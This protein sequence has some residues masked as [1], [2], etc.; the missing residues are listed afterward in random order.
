MKLQSS[1]ELQ[2]SKTWITESRK[3]T[4]KVGS[5]ET[6]IC[7]WVIVLLQQ[8]GPARSSVGK[9]AGKGDLFVA[10]RIAK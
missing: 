8:M 1:N 9:V 6:G 4:I 10:A 7:K 3:L 2:A 5:V